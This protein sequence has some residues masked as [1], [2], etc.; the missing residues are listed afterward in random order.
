MTRAVVFDIGMVL[1]EWHPEAFYDR[2]IGPERRRAF[3]AETGIAAMNERIDLGAPFLETVRAHAD[4][5]PDWRPEVMAWHDHWL[6]M[7]TPAI[8][9]SV[10]LLAALR[11]KGVPVFALSNFGV[12][13]FELACRSYPF[14]T[15]FDR[16]FVSGYLGMIKPDPRFYAAL[17]EGTGYAGADLLFADD[18]PENIAAA[19]AR[20]WQTHL[21][22][23]PEGWADRLVSEG[24]LTEGEAA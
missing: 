20:G 22:T 18:R 23:T 8:P 4:L 10:R 17:E 3:W 11:T 16:L 1:V 7:C 21:F 19:T 15:N 2:L 13:T 12:G 6:D 5:H 14:L 9:H 24:F